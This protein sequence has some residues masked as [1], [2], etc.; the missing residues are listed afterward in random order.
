VKTT[1]G[2]NAVTEVA[3]SAFSTDLFMIPFTGTSD[4]KFSLIKP[5]RRAGTEIK[6]VPEAILKHIDTSDDPLNTDPAT[7][8]AACVAGNPT[9]MT[10]RNLPALTRFPRTKADIIGVYEGGSYHDCGV[11]RPAGRCKMRDQDILT[12]PLCFVCRYIIVDTVDPTRHRELD[13]LYPE[14]S[15]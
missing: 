1:P 12:L 2:T 7:P 10:P 11:F 8:H 9:V 3:M 4:Q 5:I 13:L 15:D 6:L 14:V